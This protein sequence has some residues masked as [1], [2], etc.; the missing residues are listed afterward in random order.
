LS[1]SLQRLYISRARWFEVLE[2][3]CALAAD[4]RTSIENE[5]FL[6]LSDAPWGHERSGATQIIHPARLNEENTSLGFDWSS[7]FVK[8]QETIVRAKDN[9]GNVITPMHVDDGQG[10]QVLDVDAIVSDFDVAN[11]IY[12]QV[13]LG[14]VRSGDRNV[15]PIR[16]FSNVGRCE[17]E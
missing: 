14:V 9:N 4:M 1:R 5:G 6:R 12:A 7:V 10:G 11:Q 2:N 3:R 16:E 13:G 17:G 8:V 15:V